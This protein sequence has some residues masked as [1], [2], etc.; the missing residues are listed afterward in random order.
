MSGPPVNKAAMLPLRVAVAYFIAF[1]LLGFSHWLRD[2]FGTPTIDQIL[3]HWHY[4]AGIGVTV[5]RTF[6]LTFA[7]ECIG[8]PLLLSV[9]AT[10]LQL[11]L[12][13]LLALRWP[14]LGHWALET[15]PSV[16]AVCCGIAVLI[17]Q[18]SV[19]TWV[20]YKLGPDYFA[21]EYVNPNR[22]ALKPARL[23]NLLLIYV[24]SLEDSY[25][26]ASVWG[27]DLLEPMR[28]VGGVSFRNYHTTPGSS[29]TIAAMVATQC[30]V[31]LRFV[32][33]DLNEN[34]PELRVFLPGA[35]CLGDILH[36][37]GYRNV[38]MG[39][40]PLS[41]SGKRQF[42]QDHHYDAVYGRTEWL[43]KGI[44]PGKFNEW[45]LYDDELLQQARKKLVE[46][47][48]SGRPFNLT[49]LT[50]DTHNPHGYL[51]PTC[52]AR[53]V[54]SFEGIVHGTTAQVAEFVKCAV[55]NGYLEDTQIIVIGDHLAKSNPVYGKLLQM[56]AR[57]MFNRFISADMPPPNTEDII[58][59]DLFPSIVQ[60]LGIE[61]PGDRLGLGYTAF[62]EQHVPRPETRKAG[63]GF[64]SLS[65]SKEYERLWKQP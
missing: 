48:A 22:V 5:G 39:G 44:A 50:L 63:I 59:V 32:Q 42:L 38:F 61:V 14:A 26:D 43:N 6:V 57:R 27:R 52:R 25:G 18:L 51:S 16:V 4:S 53:G 47:H 20:G 9:G 58:P 1:S 8:F 33:T 29:W 62:S 15:V 65:G 35:I 23:K 34:G 37:Y 56:P 7:A 54:E 40:A 13:R 19:M 45:G 36:R 64:P 55:D 28:Q 21:S 30:G 3:F 2:S 12:Q 60:L 46:L 31:P 24:E 10:F 41:F 17:L 49:L 11:L